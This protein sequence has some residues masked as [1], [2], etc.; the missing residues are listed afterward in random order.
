MIPQLP[1]Y[2]K[3]RYTKEIWTGD[4]WR[5]INRKEKTETIIAIS[6]RIKQCTCGHGKTRHA[7][8]SYESKPPGS[9][10]SC[11][12]KRFVLGADYWS[13]PDRKILNQYT[14]TA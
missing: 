5:I 14:K 12:C 13:T 11:N 7:E 1:L 4:K 10:F 8:W 6:K 9:C 2:R 3:V